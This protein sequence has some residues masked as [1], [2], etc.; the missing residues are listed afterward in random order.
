MATPDRQQVMRIPVGATKILLALAL[1][2]YL[3][4]AQVTRPLYADSSLAFV[5]KILKSLVEQD[6]VFTLGGRA[7]NV[8]LIYTLSGKGRQYV[9]LLGTPTTKRFRPT[10]EREK[11]ANGFFL[12]H[13]IS[14]TD[15]LIAAYRLTQTV[16]EIILNR[17][18]LE[19]ELK[20]KIYVGIPIS[21]GNGTTL[22][23]NVCLK[24]D[25][26][27]DF[28]TH[29]TV[30]DFFHIEVYPSNLR[31]DR[32]KHKIAGYAAYALSTIH[33]ELFHT[34]SLTIAVFCATQQ[35]AETLKRWTEEVLQDR[36]LRDIG[37][38]FFFTSS[39]PATT[40]PE[41]LFLSP[42]W[43]QA[44]GNTNTPLLLLEQEKDEA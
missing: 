10:E 15:V 42:V 31:E 13:T 32:F 6:L 4:A 1:F 30:Q 5:R 3:T 36:L 28:I 37:E 17:I 25:A 12:Q 40:S 14:V 43:E 2:G 34:P 9:S 33:Q 41:E 19:R 21:L 8:P 11:A 29:D 18:Y 39:D 35:L 44:F 22:R 23:Q 38:Q 20:R 26:A 24:P 7:V 16:P 27:V